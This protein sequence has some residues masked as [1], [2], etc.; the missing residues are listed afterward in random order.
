[1]DVDVEGHI[2]L[3]LLIEDEVPIRFGGVAVD[4]PVQWVRRRGVRRPPGCAGSPQ[5][6]RSRETIPASAPT[7][8][9]SGTSSGPPSS[10]LAA[11]PGLGRQGAG[12]IRHTQHHGRVEMQRRVRRLAAIVRRRRVSTLRSFC[13]KL[14]SVVNASPTQDGG[15]RFPASVTRLRVV[16][17]T[18][19][20]IVG[21]PVKREHCDVVRRFWSI[22]VAGR[23]DVA[24]DG[25]VIRVGDAI[26]VAEFT[27]NLP[28]GS[29]SPNGSLTQLAAVM[30]WR[31]PIR[32]PPQNG[33]NRGSRHCQP[34]ARPAPVNAVL[35]HR[36]D[37][38][39][40]PRRR[41]RAQAESEKRHGSRGEEGQPSAKHY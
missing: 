31:L 23:S 26:D 32:V 5:S 39:R 13:A 6:V 8:V 19:R 27:S 15:P 33:R 30:N 16:D 41:G 22:R 7:V 11:V 29:F 18:H 2:G 1:M 4:K 36:S 10:S 24:R 12:R 37:R 38:G 25:V 34:G 40:W 21:N 35:Q 14:S 20:L 28:A 17:H 9:P 3:R